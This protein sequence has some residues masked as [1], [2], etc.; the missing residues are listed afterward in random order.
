MCKWGRGLAGMQAG[1]GQKSAMVFA[2]CLEEECRSAGEE[3]PLEK[4]GLP[5]D[6]SL[7][8]ASCL[9]GKARAAVE[10]QGGGVV[11]TGDEGLWPLPRLR[12]QEAG[13]A[14]AAEGGKDG[15]GVDVE[16][17]ARG[18]G[19]AAAAERV[20]DALPV[21]VSRSPSA[22]A[23]A[24]RAIATAVP[25]PNAAASRPTRPTYRPEVIARC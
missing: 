6:V 9:F 16:R 19:L 18:E 5:V 21:V 20:A 11:G 10:R 4:G 24:D 17:A 12:K 1:W 13:K 3:E 25:T 15:D 7:C 8:G 22:E 14:A 2:G 23:G